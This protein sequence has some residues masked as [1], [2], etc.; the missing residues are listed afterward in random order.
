MAKAAKK[1]AAKTASKTASKTATKAAAK[2]ATKKT[3]AKKGGKD[4]GGKANAAFMKPLNVSPTLAEVVGSEP[5]PR[6]EII[7]KMWEYIRANNLQDQKNKRMINADAKL[8]KVFDG[9]EQVSMF[10]LAKIVNNHVK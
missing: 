4:G 9:K 6:T 1:A 7:K 2:T 8:K 3:A 5:I 10:E